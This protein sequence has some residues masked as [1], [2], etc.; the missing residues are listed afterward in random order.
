MVA[1]VFGI[2]LLLLTLLW[3]GDSAHSQPH[4]WREP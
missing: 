3:I 2:G 4:T 1:W